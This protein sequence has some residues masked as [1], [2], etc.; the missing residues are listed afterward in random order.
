MQ[1]SLAVTVTRRFRS[2]DA[3]VTKS[4]LLLDASLIVFGSLLVA[5]LAQVRIVL[6]FTPVPI[7]GQTLAV[8]LIG[9]VLGS[10]RGAATIGLYILEGGIGLPFFAGGKAGLAV[11]MGPTG[12][13]LAGFVAAA[14]VVGWLAERG[15]D[16]RLATAFAAFVIGTAVIYLFGTIGLLR[17]MSLQAAIAGGVLPFIVGDILKAVVAGSLLPAAWALLKNLK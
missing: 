4:T 15:F 12:G 17:F 14:F 11:L 9:A 16:R 6:P 3:V 2:N 7:T 10:K 13:Y 8:L 1:N 5:L